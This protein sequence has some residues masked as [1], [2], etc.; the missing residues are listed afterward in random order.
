MPRILGIDLTGKAIVLRVIEAIFFSML[1]FAFFF[2]VPTVLPSSVS[3]FVTVTG[4]GLGSH[5]LSNLIAPTAPTLG[6]FIV[7]VVFAGVVLRGS[8]VYGPLLVLNGF[9]FALYVYSIFQGGVIRVQ[10][11][12]DA[13]GATNASLS[14][15]LDVTWIMVAFMVPPALAILKGVILIRRP[16]KREVSGPSSPRPW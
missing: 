4:G 10:A 5:V 9:A 3:G 6:L 7:L 12:G 2:Y 11:M 15:S 16:S 13:F 1:A 14:L 8:R